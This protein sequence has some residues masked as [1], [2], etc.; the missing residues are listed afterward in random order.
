MQ[1]IFDRSI[2]M[3][4]TMNKTAHSK[5]WQDDESDEDDDIA[6][7]AL[8]NS[9]FRPRNSAYNLTTRMSTARL[10][11]EGNENMFKK[12]QSFYYAWDCISLVL[13]SH[14]TVDLVIED[15]NDRMALLHV[16]THGMNKA[17]PRNC[18]ANHV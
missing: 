11:S 5:V 7:I 9:T 2:R 15:N 18:V 3:S 8:H 14:T 1:P 16:L 6:K 17:I 13:K 10:T 4:E 12:M